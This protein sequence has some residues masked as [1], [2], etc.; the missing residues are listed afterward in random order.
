VTKIGLIHTRA[1]KKRDKQQ[2]KLSKAERKVVEELHE[3]QDE[4]AEGLPWYRQRT[5]GAQITT[6][7]KDHKKES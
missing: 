6:A 7:M 2:A 1:S 5:L 4:A 3:K